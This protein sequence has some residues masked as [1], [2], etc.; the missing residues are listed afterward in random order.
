MFGIGVDIIE[1][2]RVKR[3]VLRSPRFLGQVFTAA[4]IADCAQKADYFA[5]L[6]ARFAAKE[7]V[8]KALG[9][10][11]WVQKWQQIEIRQT[12][13]V[14]T[15]ILKDDMLA[16]SEKLGIVKISLSLSHDKTQAIAFVVA[17]Q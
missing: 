1:I 10:T 15:V 13:Q 2:E 11:M 8:S 5:S 6:A 17:E 16:V 9:V 7:A 12:E 3:A 14:P 4:E